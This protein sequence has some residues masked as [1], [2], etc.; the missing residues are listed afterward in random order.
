MIAYI[1]TTGLIFALITAA[2]LLRLFVEPHFARDPFYIALTLVAAAMSVWAWRL[3]W[4][5]MRA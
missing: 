4:L 5:S 3:V 1:K 2:H